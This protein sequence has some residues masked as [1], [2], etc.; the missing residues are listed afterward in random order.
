MVNPSYLTQDVSNIGMGGV[1]SHIDQNGYEQV[2]TYGSWLFCHKA[3]VV[4][5]CDICEAHSTLFSVVTY[6]QL[7][8]L[9]DQSMKFCIGIK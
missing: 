5:C 4:G 6:G 1:L 3:R 2:V 8:A 9:T 7:Y